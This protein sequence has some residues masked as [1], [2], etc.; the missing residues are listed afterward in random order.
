M[1]SL[2]HVGPLARSV[3]EL[4]LAYDVMQGPDARDPA[5]AARMA[6]HAMPEFESGVGGLRIAMLSGYF[7]RGGDPAAHAAVERVAA[8][9]GTDRRIELSAV[10]HAR[11]AAFVIT[12]TEGRRLHLDRL[13]TRAAEFD[14]AVLDRLLAGALLPAA[15]YI[16][17]QTFRGWWRAHVRAAFDDVDVLLAPATPVPATHLGQET[18]TMGG[19][20]LLVRPNLGL[21]TQPISFI[22]LPVVAAPMP[23]AAGP[24]PLAV[25]IIGAPWAEASVLRVA[26]YLEKHG[27]CAAP[28]TVLP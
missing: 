15:W 10:E 20:E 27:V 24:L 7:S 11:A 17:A 4:A 13:R 21:F 25:Q 3:A 8:A 1:A 9:L 14:P 2:D 12:A 23:S 16:H 18:M 19:R 5:C 6:E 28:V 22:G 26:R